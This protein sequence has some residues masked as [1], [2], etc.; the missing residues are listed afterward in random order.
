MAEYQEL[1]AQIHERV[2]AMTLAKN[3]ADGYRAVLV[4]CRHA[5]DPA[6]RTSELRA[7]A[8]RSLRRLAGNPAMLNLIID[9]ACT[10]AGLSSVHATQAL[11]CVGSG[12][13]PTLLARYGRGSNVVQSQITAVLIAMGEAAFPVMVQEVAADVP[14]RA[15]SAARL[16]GRMQN[17]RSTDVLLA[18]LREPDDELQREAARALARIGTEAAVQGLLEAAGELPELRS[19]V[20]T[21]LGETRSPAAVRALAQILDGR[22]RYPE[23][24]QREA[25]RSLGRI[26]SAEALAALKR[27]LGRQTFF[28]R[29]RTRI[30]RIAAAR[31]IGRIGGDDASLVLGEHAVDA[32]PAVRKA[33]RES[34]ERMSRAE[35]R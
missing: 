27:V 8:E 35:T 33:S 2:E 30:L 24:E 31:A 1:A 32:D 6:A 20:T 29:K 11:I 23:H 18:K 19:A 15:R 3:V 25:I 13:V 14:E 22:S 4:C 5:T 28:R 12:V 21:C 26:R 16:L 17:P 34:L 9:H 10:G 7:E